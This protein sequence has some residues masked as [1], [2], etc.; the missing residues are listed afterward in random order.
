MKLRFGATDRPK[1]VALQTQDKLAIQEELKKTKLLAGE[2]KIA[3]NYKDPSTAAENA[4]RVVLGLMS[5]GMA[6]TARL[7]LARAG[8]KDD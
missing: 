2:S 3:K 8:L 6:R 7:N 4:V 1:F 5:H